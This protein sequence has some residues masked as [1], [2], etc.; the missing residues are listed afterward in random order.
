MQDILCIRIFLLII[1]PI[2]PPQDK[3][4]GAHTNT[5]ANSDTN[6]VKNA[7]RDTN[8]NQIQIQKQL[9]RGL[10]HDGCIRRRQGGNA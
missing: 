8:T 3:S 10:P 5:K 7:N 9:P 6:T 1:K 4:M 2:D